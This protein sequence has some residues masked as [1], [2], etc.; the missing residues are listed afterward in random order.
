MFKNLIF[1]V[2]LYNHTFKM[3]CG[4]DNYYIFK[5]ENVSN[6]ESGTFYFIVHSIVIWIIFTFYSC[7]INFKFVID[8]IFD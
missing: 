7:N 4:L 2:Y 1:Y 6:N 5:I 8:I 3:Y